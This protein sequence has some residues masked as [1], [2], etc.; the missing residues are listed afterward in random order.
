MYFLSEKDQ[1]PMSK[2]YKN[3]Q[4]IK[5]DRKRGICKKFGPNFAKFT[6]QIRSENFTNKFNFYSHK[7]RIDPHTCF[8]AYKSLPVIEHTWIHA[9]KSV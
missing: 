9:Y 2:S 6:C 5:S 4:G 8:Y 7:K 1:F 3:L